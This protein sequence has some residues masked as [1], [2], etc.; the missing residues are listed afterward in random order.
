MGEPERR[1]VRGTAGTKTPEAGRYSHL[2][3]GHGEALTDAW[4]NPYAEAGIAI[5]AKRGGACVPHSA[6]S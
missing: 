1:L 4:S 6:T 2:P 3:P 5:A